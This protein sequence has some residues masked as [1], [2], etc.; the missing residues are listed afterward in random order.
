[1]SVKVDDFLDFLLFEK[2]TDITLNSIPERVVITDAEKNTDYYIDDKNVRLKSPVNTGSI[3]DF[4][5]V[6]WLVMSQV[7]ATSISHEA[8]IRKCNHI[9]K[10][11]LNDWVYEFNSILQ[12]QSLSFE[13][14]IVMTVSG[15]IYCMLQDNE[16]SRQIVINQ[17][18]IAS[19][20][21][22]KIVGLDTTHTGLIVLNAEC[23]ETSAYDDMVNEIADAGRLPVWSVQILNPTDKINKDSEY[24]FIGKVF[25]DNVECDEPV[26]W[27]SSDENIVT[28]VD[29]VATGIDVGTATITA[30][31][32]AHPS[33]YCE[34]VL[35]VSDV[36]PVVVTYRMYTYIVGE[37]IKDYSDFNILQGDT[38]VYG[39]EKYYDGVLA[40]D[41]DTY[42]YTLN[43]N[44]VPTANYVYTVVNAYTVKIQNKAKYLD[45][46]MILTG[47]SNQSGESLSVNIQL[48]GSW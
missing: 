34:F 14:G 4:Q 35:E 9:T 42:T 7:K 26:I 23:T 31:C 45:S 39:I 1:M 16:L 38:N 20:S 24:T 18:F 28:I 30:Y 13:N 40:P 8:K 48:K 47:K 43:R 36:V 37:E 29:G 32:K 44:G 12:M 10:F 33:V 15:N 25:K 5:D 11:I 22:W 41:N 17:R 27:I 3:V 6:K 19:C 2:G 21:A 46:L